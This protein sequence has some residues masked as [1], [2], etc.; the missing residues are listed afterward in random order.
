MP[1]CH[2]SCA[3]FGLTRRTFPYV[4]GIVESAATRRFEF[5]I[6]HA[7][8]FLHLACVRRTEAG[9]R[10]RLIAPWQASLWILR[11]IAAI[12]RVGA[13]TADALHVD[14]GDVLV[15]ALACLRA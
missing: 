2:R 15:E 10:G 12:D 6:E 13:H 7:R 3:T 11:T 14:R 9:R 1:A 5:A 4:H 8:R